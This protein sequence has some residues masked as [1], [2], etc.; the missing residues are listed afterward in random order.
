M[1]PTPDDAA[2]QI[3]F[4][5]MLRRYFAKLGR[6]YA[7]FIIG[8]V[9]LLIVVL[10]VPT[11]Q[12]LN[13]TQSG[14]NFAT[15]TR[16]G[17]SSSGSGTADTLLDA[18]GDTVPGSS[19]DTGS[20][21][22]NSASGPGANFLGA[23]GSD[24]GVAR[25]GMKCGNG[26]RQFTWSSHSPYCEAEFKGNNGGATGQG[27]TKDTITLTFR[28]P[29]SAQ[30]Q[31][32]GAAAGNANV[33]YDAMIADMQTYISFFNK[34]FELYGRKV[35]LKPFKGQGDYIQ[36][37]QGQNLAG[38]QADAVTAHDMGA[39]GDVTFS[40][41]ASQPYE[42]DLADQ[43]VM[44]FSPI[45]QPQS[46]FEQYAPYE[47]SVQG[48]SGTVGIQ[49]AAAFV[50]RR[51]AKLP[52]IFSGDTVDQKRTRV[53]GII[54]PEIPTYAQLASQYEGLLKQGCGVTV[55]Q[56]SGY[57]VNVAQFTNQAATI[58]AQM[59]SQG[60]TTVLCACDPIF[61][62]FLTR[63]ASGQGYHPEWAAVLAG[64]PSGRLYEQSE[65]SHAFGGGAQSPDPKTTEP[66]KVYKLANPGKEPAEGSANGGPPY[67]SVPYYTLLH[68]FEGLQA[69]GPNLTAANFQKGMFSLPPSDIDP[70]GGKWVFGPNVY[71]PVASFSIAYWDP[72]AK[73]AFDGET[74]RYSNCNGGQIYT[75]DHLE[76]LGGPGEQLHCFGK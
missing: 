10:L 41:G 66:Y 3:A 31:A 33:N 59:R 44:S 51:M 7:P 20:S 69:A 47:W 28:V 75:V 36:E 29:S 2:Q 38:A 45:G 71:D 11:T 68:V 43:H 56:K 9:C 70:I 67:F 53:F 18:T 74:G 63:S 40:L 21:G 35:V 60:V 52:A 62:I 72:N 73:S 24:S 22:D 23:G 46:W 76:A 16:R 5:A 50:C 12:P 27:A 30:D 15:G 6:R 14:S 61:P 39:F 58:S 54:Y 55:A 4:E 8:A 49:S 48:A 25:T 17:P 37:D 42:Q 64:D 19:S 1:A 26:A 65:W 13:T 32:I 57:A 34:Q